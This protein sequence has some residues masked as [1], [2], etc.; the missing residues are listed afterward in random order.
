MLNWSAFVTLFLAVIGCTIWITRKLERL[1]H[2]LENIE[3]RVATIEF[4]N[5]ALLRAFPQ[6]VSSLISGKIVTIEQG[7][8]MISTALASPPIAE[9]LREI[10]PTVNPLS[11]DD[12]D[13]LRNYVGRMQ[14]GET[15]NPLEGMDFYRITNIVAAE[16]PNNESSWLLFLI[17]GIVL[18]LLLADAKK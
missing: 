15:L 4:Q 6:V 17:G 9:F 5:R 1:E 16:Y 3:L 8:M 18:G 12:V 14:A 13:R 7:T 2:R 10:K 11:Q